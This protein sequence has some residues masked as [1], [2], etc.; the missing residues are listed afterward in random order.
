MDDE[1]VHSI[2]KAV[3]EVR[4]GRDGIHIR[5]YAHHATGYRHRDRGCPDA[6]LAAF[7]DCHW[8]SSGR[9]DHVHQG[10]LIKPRG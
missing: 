2:V 6:D 5:E 1:I 3:G 9:T 8:R 10:R 7:G 4:C